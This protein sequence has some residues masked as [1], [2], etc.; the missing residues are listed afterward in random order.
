MLKL[1]KELVSVYSDQENCSACVWPK[2]GQPG[3]SVAMGISKEEVVKRKQAIKSWSE[4]KVKDLT[5]KD[6]KAEVKYDANKDSLE[7]TFTPDIDEE[8]KKIF[9][10]MFEGLFF[11]K[12][13]K[14]ISQFI[15][16]SEEVDN[17]VNDV[18]IQK[19]NLIKGV[20]SKQAIIV[21]PSLYGKNIV[22]N[23]RTTITK[24]E[25]HKNDRFLFSK[26]N[27]RVPYNYQKTMFN[28]HVLDKEI[29]EAVKLA[30]ENE[31]L[32]EVE[33]KDDEG[34]KIVRYKAVI[35]TKKYKFS[36]HAIIE[37]I[38][39]KEDLNIISFFPT[40]GKDTY[41]V[42]STASNRISSLSPEY[43][44]ATRFYGKK[45]FLAKPITS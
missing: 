28:S 33:F 39:S 4:T 45:Y 7:I 34:N 42:E 29:I 31:L 3:V 23:G 6:V 25:Q 38:V 11:K 18:N 37:I 40:G 9:E 26:S 41:V 17:F 44:E 20:D 14:S 27:E 35:D 12:D 15:S 5:G 36:W 43:I 22:L 32:I 8:K 10:K 30:L 19:D 21:I 1:S 13:Q 16:V 24:M 2:P